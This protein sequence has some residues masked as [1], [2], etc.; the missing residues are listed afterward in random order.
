MTRGTG[1]LSE[2]EG[3]IMYLRWPIITRSPSFTQKHGKMCAGMFEYLFSYLNMVS[4]K[5]RNDTVNQASIYIL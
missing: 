1:K 2:I 5:I 3:E 4:R